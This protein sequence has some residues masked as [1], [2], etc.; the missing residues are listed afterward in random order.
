MGV[1]GVSNDMR[2]VL[3][4][5]GGRRRALPAGPGDL[6]LPVEEVRRRLRGG[7]GRAGR[8]RLHR[9]VGENSPDIRARCVRVSAFWVSTWTRRRTRR[10]GVSTPTSAASGSR[11][12][13]SGDSH[14]RGAGH[15]RRDGG[16]GDAGPLKAAEATP[17]AG[18]RWVR[19][20]HRL[21]HVS[22]GAARRDPV[23]LSEARPLTAGSPKERRPWSSKSC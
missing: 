1:S 19:A 18:M 17:R 9:G 8:A 21:A 15:R 22:A 6:L 10:R 23:L 7:D 3:R 20:A 14:R 2:D 13:V 4:G 16:G 12:R 5:R 11:V